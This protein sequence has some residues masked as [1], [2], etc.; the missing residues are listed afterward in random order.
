MC[1][2]QITLGASF[3]GPWAKLWRKK[4]KKQFLSR[5]DNP[6]CLLKYHCNLNKKRIIQCMIHRITQACRCSFT[7]KA[8]IHVHPGPF[9]WFSPLSRLVL[10][11]SHQ[12]DLLGL[13]SLR[14]SPGA[15]GRRKTLSALIK[16]LFRGAKWILGSLLEMSSSLQ[17][18]DEAW[19]N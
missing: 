10:R 4:N 13:C 15:S 3:K 2:V 8:Q 11:L 1:G 19:T 16:R 9:L 17:W 18:L 12:P 14:S 5:S 7:W 6:T